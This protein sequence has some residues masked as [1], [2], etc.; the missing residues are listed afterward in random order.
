MRELG[1]IVGPNRQ[2]ACFSQEAPGS[3]EYTQSSQSTHSGEKEEEE[4]V[5]DPKQVILEKALEFMPTY[6]YVVDMLRRVS[7]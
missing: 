5:H 3:E 4:Y 7:V 1:S 2:T 6:G